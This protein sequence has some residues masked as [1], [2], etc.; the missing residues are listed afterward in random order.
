MGIHGNEW[1]SGHRLELNTIEIKTTLLFYGLV[2]RDDE[3][4]MVACQNG[5][6]M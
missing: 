4:P 6:E 2:A 5:V 1:I 3:N